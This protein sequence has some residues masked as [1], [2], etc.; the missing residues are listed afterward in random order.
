MQAATLIGHENAYSYYRLINS[1]YDE[2]HNHDMGNEKQ[3]LN[4]I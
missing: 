3:A 2:L 4:R 1:I